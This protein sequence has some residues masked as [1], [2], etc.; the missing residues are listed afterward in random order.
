M[1]NDKVKFGKQFRIWYFCPHTKTMVKNINNK[2]SNM[3]KLKLAR[4]ISL[5]AAAPLHLKIYVPQGERNTVVPWHFRPDTR[6]KF[7][8]CLR[9]ESC[10]VTSSE[11]K[12]GVTH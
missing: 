8:L 2:V 12:H 4:S 10:G 1:V 5:G 11:L 3:R 9:F 7:L 6:S